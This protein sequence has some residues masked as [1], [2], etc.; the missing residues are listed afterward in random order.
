MLDKRK[1]KFWK[2]YISIISFVGLSIVI[3]IVI[4]LNTNIYRPITNAPVELVL[5]ASDEVVRENI[6]VELPTIYSDTLTRGWENWSWDTHLDFSSY[7]SLERDN[8]IRVEFNK[9]N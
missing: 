5:G 2:R 1:D 7:V 8:S 4:I 9:P 3:G 6:F